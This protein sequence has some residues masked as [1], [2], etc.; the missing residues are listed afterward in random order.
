MLMKQ[1]G[2]GTQARGIPFDCSVY[3]L[4][5]PLLQPIIALVVQLAEPAGRSLI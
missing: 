2:G 3:Y 4:S 5:C 1:K